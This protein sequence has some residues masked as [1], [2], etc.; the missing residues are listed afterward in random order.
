LRRSWGVLAR[1]EQSKE[2]K[3]QTMRHGE[4][5]KQEVPSGEKTAWWENNM[6]QINYTTHPSDPSG[7]RLQHRTAGMEHFHK[8]VMFQI[9]KLHTI[10][11]VFVMNLMT[12]T[13][14][15]QPHIFHLQILEVK[16]NPP[17]TAD[18]CTLCLC[19]YLITIMWCL[20]IANALYYN[21]LLTLETLNKLGVAA[22]IFNHWFAMLQQVKKSGA[23]VNF[24]R[25][26]CLLSTIIFL[27]IPTTNQCC[28]IVSFVEGM[29]RKPVLL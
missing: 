19:L 8:N 9:G 18:S 29:I 6:A 26:G 21:P 7:G 10:K 24:K 13:L 12:S 28:Y 14:S 1:E 27:H 22:D 4:R 3:K 2:A 17:F 20:Q 23:R 5:N 15:F 25:Y 16:T 11:M